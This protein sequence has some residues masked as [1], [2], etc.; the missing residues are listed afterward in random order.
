M[1]Q[2]SECK[3]QANVAFL[4]FNTS[5]LCDKN[6][7]FTRDF[8]LCLRFNVK[9]N[10][11]YLVTFFTQIHCVHYIVLFIDVQRKKTVFNIPKTV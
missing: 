5:S 10:C 1:F 9:A 6:D 4:F 7:A 11:Q 8:E 3:Q 2:A